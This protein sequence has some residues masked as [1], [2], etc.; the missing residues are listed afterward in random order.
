MANTEDHLQDVTPGRLSDHLP[1]GVIAQ[2]RR[3]HQR[4][5][6]LPARLVAYYV[7]A[8]ALFSAGAYDEV[9]R[10]MVDGLKFVAA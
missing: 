8:L 9:M 1:L 5:Q 2:T 3:G 10:K 4:N 7:I 6:L